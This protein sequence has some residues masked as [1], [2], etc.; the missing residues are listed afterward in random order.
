MSELLDDLRH[1]A[2]T[3][4]LGLPEAALGKLEEYLALLERWNRVYNLTAVR[5][6]ERMVPQHLLDSLAVLPHIEGPRVL[7]VGSGAGLPGIPLAIAHADWQVVL[8]ESNSKKAAFLRQALIE[9]K[10]RNAEV[11]EE[12]VEEYAGTAF[13]VV[14]CRAFSDLPEFLRL[15]G[16]LCR[17]GGVLAAMKGL[18]PYEELAQI[19]AGFRLR[20]VADLA[21]PGIEGARH[22]VLVE[23]AP[24]SP[25]A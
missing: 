13:D 18:Y 15:A 4:A 11:V 2:E 24:V 16:R 1:G 25:D 19:P 7:D 12:R 14:I 23:P 8:L 21:V 10:L 22:L 17:P 6:P 3:L 20:R 9:L 5:E